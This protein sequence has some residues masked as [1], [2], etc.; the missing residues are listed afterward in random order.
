[1]EKKKLSQ[2]DFRAK[3]YTDRECVGFVYTLDEDDPED[4]TLIFT[5]ARSKYAKEVWSMSVMLPG[6][7]DMQRTPYSNTFSVPSNCSLAFVAAVGL[8]QYVSSMAETYSELE[9]NFLKINAMCEEV[10]SIG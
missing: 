10:F 6:I 2:N 9:K 5:F 1:M 4:T 8:K 3:W 7:G